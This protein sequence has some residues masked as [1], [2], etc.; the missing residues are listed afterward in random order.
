MNPQHFRRSRN[1]VN[2]ISARTRRGLQCWLGVLLSVYLASS[3]LMLIGVER[4]QAMESVMP[5][6]ICAQALSDAVRSAPSLSAPDAERQAF[7]PS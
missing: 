7:R 1:A 3:H 6:D 2:D 5:E 4:P